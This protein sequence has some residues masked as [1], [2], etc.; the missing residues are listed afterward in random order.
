[1][2]LNFSPERKFSLKLRRQSKR[3]LCLQK[4]SVRIR[5]NTVKKTILVAAVRLFCLMFLL[6]IYPAFAIAP[7]VYDYDGDGRTDLVVGRFADGAYTWYILKS[8]KGFSA[9]V[10]GG[11]ISGLY[12]DRFAPGDY[13]G[14][15][16]WDI[17]IKRQYQDQVN[18]NFF[19]LNSRD[20][21]IT[22][23]EWGYYFDYLALQD[24]DGDKKTDFGVW[25]GGTWYIW[26]SM[27][28]YREEQFGLPGGTGGGYRDFPV[29]GDYDGDGIGD[30]AVARS[31]NLPAISPITFFVKRSSD[32]QVQES[33]PFGDGPGAIYTPGDYDGDG[34]T[35]YAVCQGSIEVSGCN[36]FVWINSSNG[37]FGG[38]RFPDIPLRFY[39]LTGDFDGDGK[40]DPVVYRYD[41]QNPQII[42]YIWGSRDGLR[43]EPWGLRSLDIVPMKPNLAYEY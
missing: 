5:R 43:T 20:N 23:F 28:G 34:K 22:Y 11:G 14:D 37:T 31:R 2:A 26:Q 3:P 39:P 4:G 40:T 42:F 27:N 10:W 9:N 29:T 19:I 32:N 24:Y 12:F 15:G 33:Q 16:V 1:L 17:A 25:R 8:S 41:N 6:Q 21:T 18:N 35:D 13:D 30:L 36:Y 38:L 7:N